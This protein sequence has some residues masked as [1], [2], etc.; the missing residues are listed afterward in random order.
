MCYFVEFKAVFLTTRN[1]FGFKHKHGTDIC[2][3]TLK[4]L[5]RYH[6]KHGPVLSEICDSE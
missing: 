6:I 5:I 4:G 3:F 1:K 2:V